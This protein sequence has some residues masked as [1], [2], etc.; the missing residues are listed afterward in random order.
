MKFYSS[1]II[2]APREKVVKYFNDPS[3]LSKYQDTFLRKE[4]I[5]GEF[6][7]EG[8]QSMMYY[9]QGKGEMELKE[10]IV[11]SNL[12]DS[13][14]GL[15]EHKHMDNTL[16]VTFTDLGNNQ[17]KYETFTHYTRIDW[18]I[19]RIVMTL[20]KGQFKKIANKWNE[21]FKK[22]VEESED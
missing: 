11:E 18:I 2:N 13:F 20:F 14:K 8:S 7:K 10:T 4:L 21:N 5:N 9:Q 19:P 3:N 12:P 15:Y 22:L 17:T 16:E 1:I 6:Q